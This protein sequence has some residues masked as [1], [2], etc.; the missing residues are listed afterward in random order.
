LDLDNFPEARSFQIELYRDANGPGRLRFRDDELGV[1]VEFPWWNDVDSDLRRWSLDDVP[2]GDSAE[3]FSDEDQEW[4]IVIWRSGA[5]VYIMEGDEDRFC[6]WI[7]TSAGRYLD[8]WAVL[9]ARS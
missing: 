4:R 9:L 7:T 6:T 2:I 8:Q 3:P 1:R 5:R